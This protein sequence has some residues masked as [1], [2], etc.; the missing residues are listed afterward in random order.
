MMACLLSGFCFNMLMYGRMNGEIHYH[1]EKYE[2]LE[3]TLKEIKEK[4]DKIEGGD[5]K[6]LK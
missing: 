5:V 6:K 1:A 3:K 4:L 2:K